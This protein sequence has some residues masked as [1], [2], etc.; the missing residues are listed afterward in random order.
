[1]KRGDL[2][3]C[4]VS[5]ARDQSRLGEVG[6]VVD[7]VTHTETYASSGCKNYVVLTARGDEYRCWKG[8]LEVISETR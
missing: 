6:I 4:I 8:E 2:V 5:G 7:I 3:R 1:V